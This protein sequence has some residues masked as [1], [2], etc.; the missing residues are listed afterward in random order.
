M[1]DK[2]RI[3]EVMERVAG[4]ATPVL[5]LYI[6]TNPAQRE[7]SPRAIAIRAKCTLDAL[8]VPDDLAEKVVRLVETDTPRARA[9]AVF[10]TDQDVDVLRLGVE[11]PVEDPVTG[12]VAARWGKPYILPLLLSLDESERYAVLS[13]DREQWRLFAVARDAIQELE[14]RTRPVSPAE[15]D[16]LQ[17]SKQEHPAYIPTR[18]GAARDLADDH[19]EALVRR[20]YQELAGLLQSALERDGHRNLIA[21]GAERDVA[22]LRTVLPLALA[23]CIVATL[24]SLP[25]AGFSPGEMLAHV[26]D[27]LEQCKA[28][29]E[30]QLLDDI[31][32][33]GITGLDACL[34]ALQQGRLQILAVPWPLPDGQV[35][36]ELESGYVA[37]SEQA[38]RAMR[39]DGAQPVQATYLGDVLAELASAFNTRLEF[40]VGDHK[41]RLVQ[42]FGGLGGVARW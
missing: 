11:L 1:I 14:H 15:Q 31:G 38:A 16:R 33:R 24:P 42:G 26:S 39:P 36:R 18:G 6:N 28:A 21:V 22:R 10:A 3:R 35:Y 19:I 8:A 5:S 37:T 23:D 30:M 29:R 20:F 17:Q 41:E 4:Y 27:A 12:H 2:K 9:M 34:G 40:V 7:S 13:L 32:E 25:S